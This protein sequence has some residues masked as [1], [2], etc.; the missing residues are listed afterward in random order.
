M[1]KASPKVSL[2]N[3]L[4]WLDTYQAM[5]DTIVALP[6]ETFSKEQKVELVEALAMKVCAIWSICAEDLLIDCLNKNSEQYADFMGVSR[7]PKHI[8]RTLCEFMING[9]GFFDFKNVDDLKKKAKDILIDQNNP[10]KDITPADR[11]KID[12]LF[13]MRNYVAHYSIMSG[14]RLGKIYRN[15]YHM[16]NFVEPGY[17]LLAI[18]IGKAPKKPRFHGYLDAM[19]SASNAMA[20]SLN[21]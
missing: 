9:I 3:L 8:P 15:T 7:M 12:E 13:T 2:K 20:Q 5:F 21:L 18:A 19:R 6:K 1:K 14:R 17:F 11:K 4:D 10:F 16:K